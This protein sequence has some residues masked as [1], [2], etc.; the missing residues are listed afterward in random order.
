M[1]N[2]PIPDITAEEFR[3]KY[4]YNPETGVISALYGKIGEM[5][6][7]NSALG[8]TNSDGYC[9]ICI[10]YKQYNAS[11]LAHLY[12]TGAWPE[13]GK[14]MDHINGIKNDNRWSNLRCV[15]RSENIHN[16]DVRLG[17]RFHEQC[18]QWE[19][20]I[21]INNKKINLGLFAS[22]DSAVRGLS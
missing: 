15:S 1:K 11:R 20:R 13:K 17:V 7:S 12:M 10:G 8:H 6:P 2:S 14:H 9:I 19:A 22:K 16:T 5:K 21:A 18:K 4:H 3:S